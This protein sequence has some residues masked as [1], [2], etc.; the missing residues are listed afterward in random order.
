VNRQH[1]E[2]MALS[3]L[4]RKAELVR[5]GLTQQAIADAVGC[6]GVQVSRVLAGEKL[7]SP[8]GQRV[9][10]YIADQLGLPVEEVFPVEPVTV[11]RRK[12]LVG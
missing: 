6:S 10:R 7:D 4:D 2:I 12:E 11:Y 9:M 5:R 3:T 1:G 8:S